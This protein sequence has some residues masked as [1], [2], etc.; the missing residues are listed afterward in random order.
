MSDDPAL[1]GAYAGLG[2]AARAQLHDAR[3][4]ELAGGGESAARLGAIPY[5]RERGSDPAGG[6]VR[7]LAAAAGHCFATGFH[8]AVTDLGA[9]GR[10]LTRPER[11]PA[12]WWLFTSLAAAS[13]AALGRGVEAEA[14]YDEARRAST[15]PGMH[16]AAAYETAMLYARHHDVS[17]R[18][19]VAAQPW[20][21]E[22]IA[23]ARALPDAAD[24]AFNLAFGM[25]GLALV[26]MRSGNPDRALKL[27]GEGLELFDRD[28]PA[29]SHPLDRCSLLANRARLLTMK[30]ALTAA[31]AGHD[32]LI[33]LDPTYGEYHF[34]R[35]NLLHLLGRDDDALAAYAEAE[36]LSLPFPELHYNRADLLAGRGEQDV[37][38]ADLDRVLE[39]DPDFLDAY[40]NRAGILAARDDGAAA[41]PDVNAGLARD[42]G[43]P[44][45][46]CILGQLEAAGGRVAAALA[47]F[48]A[49]VAAQPGLSAAW[50]SRAALRLEVG[51][52]DAAVTDL[53]RALEQG[54]DSCL[55][56][57]RAV[58]HKAAG[59]LKA[60]RD[61]AERSLTLHPGDPE[62]LAL[63]AEITPRR[64]GRFR[65]RG[66]RG[67][68]RK[69][70][71]RG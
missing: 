46:L 15:D 3:A 23:F 30:G 10:G 12:H 50:A 29:G 37:A 21:N 44:Y 66:K 16:A 60:A 32:A 57:N 5:H 24:R 35:G 67:C 1:L 51:D 65:G 14:L 25:N 62:T 68:P 13:L 31:L 43:N 19:P 56:F 36:R 9:R 47:A 27:V 55:L 33:A 26:E 64:R 45:L 28:L 41:W 38:L 22:A 53:T 2:A 71:P 42:P 11:D 61:D 6:G 20:I 49:A 52:P 54:E 70:K 40:V 59:R 7:A 34:E 39:L 48:D 69:A 17:R 58:A 63:L 4:D 8:A 18:D